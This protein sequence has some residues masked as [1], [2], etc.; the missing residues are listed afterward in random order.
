MSSIYRLESI[1]KTFTL[2]IFVESSNLDVWQNC[3]YGLDSEY[4]IIM[5]MH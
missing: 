1:E 2:S 4:A 3:K 5:N